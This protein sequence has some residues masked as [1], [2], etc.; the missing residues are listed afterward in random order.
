MFLEISHL[1]ISQ[2]MLL[3]LMSDCLALAFHEFLVSEVKLSVVDFIKRHLRSFTLPDIRNKVSDD[4][5]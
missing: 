4:V 5:V 1:Q 2:C 3:H